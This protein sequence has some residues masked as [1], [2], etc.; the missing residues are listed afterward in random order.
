MPACEHVTSEQARARYL[1]HHNATDD[2]GYVAMLQA[3]IALL[4]QHAPQAKRLLDYGCGPTPVLV[5]LLQGEGLDASGYDPL[6]AA[7]TPLSPPFD[8]VVCIETFE[9]FTNP[10]RELERLRGLLRPGGCLAVSTLFHQGP[11]NIAGWWYARDATHVALYSPATLDWI[12]AALGWTLLHRDE[13][14]LAVLRRTG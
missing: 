3:P 9:H 10:R 5:T 6:F 7:D 4:R 2:R 12:C 11:E 13:R 1:Q 14:N 8:A